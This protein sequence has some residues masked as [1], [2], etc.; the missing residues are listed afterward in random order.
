MRVAK[1]GGMRRFPCLL[2]LVPTFVLALPLAACGG[3]V[4][5]AGPTDTLA[6]SANVP[7]KPSP[8]PVPSP[9]PPDEAEP[10][11]VPTSECGID[12][13]AWD[14]GTH[15]LSRLDVPFM[16]LAPIGVLR[17]LRE[18]APQ[19]TAEESLEDLTITHDGAI[20]ALTMNG[21]IARI[22]ATEGAPT[23]S[24]V[25]QLDPS[26]AHRG[27]VAMRRSKRPDHL[28]VLETGTSA[29]LLADGAYHHTIRELDSG[30][31]RELARHRVDATSFPEHLDASPRAGLFLRYAD[32]VVEVSAEG[33]E[34]GTFTPPALSKWRT[35]L[36]TRDTWFAIG[37][38]HDAPRG[39]LPTYAYVFSSGAATAGPPITPTVTSN[40]LAVGASACAV[41]R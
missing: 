11:P 33:N 7:A 22:V 4:E 41:E 26:R 29:E 31:M 15:V 37:D 30:T 28:F 39:G 2:A 9:S 25:T 3:A 34:L 32:K 23:C 17:C 10:R 12:A 6:P 14:E 24:L 16:H 18:G 40:R 35:T 38:V 5:G 20:F 1:D 8:S 13:L 27:I 19:G 21:Y 36:S